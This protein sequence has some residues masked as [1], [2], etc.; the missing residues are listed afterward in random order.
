MWHRICLTTRV[1]PRTI[2]SVQSRHSQDPALPLWRRLRRRFYYLLTKATFVS[3]RR[4]PPSVG[5]GLC[6]GL[7]RMALL[8]RPRERSRASTN[9][10]LAF[11]ELNPTEREKLLGESALALGR[12]LYDSLTLKQAVR[13]DFAGVHDDGTIATVSK[14]R[15]H[16]RGVLI[17]TGHLGCWEL[18]GA[19]LAARLGGLAVVTGTVHNRPVDRLLQ[20]QRRELGIVPLPRE[21]DLR[22][23][24]RT[25]KQGGV[26]AVLL[27]QNTRVQ[28]MD[29]PFFGHPAPTAMGFGK[30]ALRYRVPVLPVAI[31][32]G[33]DGHH[34]VHLPLVELSVGE[35]KSVVVEF[36]KKCNFALE[37]LI[38]RN[39]AEWVWFHQR[40]PLPITR[41][42]GRQQEPK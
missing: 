14:L 24:V 20:E 6:V 38:R 27:D 16:G 21:G 36:L 23:L 11:P 4:L 30:L 25:L 2:E 41:Y 28:N 18:L 8:V 32:R 40:W 37:T 26:V 22:P 12:N 31:A 17:L 13:E 29:V 10:A 7:A 5:R 34:V 35:N 1:P 9:L 33:V 3:V 15:N 42:P 19:F 39:P